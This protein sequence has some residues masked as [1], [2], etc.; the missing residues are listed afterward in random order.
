MKTVVRSAGQENLVYVLLSD[1]DAVL[2]RRL[3]KRP[4]ASERE[5]ELARRLRDELKAVLR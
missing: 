3:L 2:L 1:A 4:A 5:A